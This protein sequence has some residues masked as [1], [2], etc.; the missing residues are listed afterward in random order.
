MIDALLARLAETAGVVPSYWDLNGVLQE[1]TPDTTRILL[2]T[3]GYAADTSADIR[4]SLRIVDRN[5]CERLL[6]EASVM[7]ES[8]VY[9]TVPAALTERKVRWTLACDDGSARDGLVDLSATAPTAVQ[10]VDGTAFARFEVPLPADIPFG[11]H[12]ITVQIGALAAQGAVICAPRTAYSPEWLKR[13]QRMWGTSCQLYTLRSRQDWGIGDFSDLAALAEMTRAAGGSTVAINPL[14]AL[15]PHRP[16]LCSPYW[17]SS[18]LFINPLYLD[19]TAIPELKDCEAAKELLRDPRFPDRIAQVRASTDVDY[20]RVTRLK[21]DLLEPIV[22]HLDRDPP[23]ELNGFIAEGGTALQHF[24]V[25]CALSDHFGGKSWHAWPEAYQNPAN[26]QVVRWTQAHRRDVRFHLLLQWL[27]QRQFAATAQRANGLEIGLMRDLAVGIS[28]DG[29]DAWTDQKLYPRGTRFGAPPDVFTASGQDWGLPPPNPRALA[30]AGYRPFIAAM[31]SNMANA[32]ALRIDH[33][34]SLERLFWIPTGAVAKDGAYVRY[35]FED[36]L[37]IV[38]LESLRA[39]CLVVGEDLG[40]M[41]AD[42]RARMQQEN[43]LST[44]VFLFER[45]DSMLFKRPALYPVSAAAQ[46]TTHDTPTLAGYWQ[47]RDLEIRTGIFHDDLPKQ[48]AERDIDRGRILAALRDQDLIGAGETPEVEKL[49]LAIHRFMARTP[50]QLMLVSAGD[51]M[52]AVEQVNLPG[53]MDEYPNWRKK[54][55]LLLEELAALPAWTETARA[56][57]EGRATGL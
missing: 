30:E 2:K 7:R 12:Q 51:I 20:A 5:T 46:A 6:P 16:E 26:D 8:H 19:L 1:T 52:A 3:M 49:I 53:T 43:V 11:Y 9:V 50:S 42:F 57:S 24:A 27:V 48:Q 38:A 55:P 34:M 13:G 29:A 54:L 36:L 22:N 33:V 39:R 47:G 35:P 10:A 45:Y 56:V 28:P 17:P 25:F 23:A 41:A 4:D 31:R 15:F 18:R 37:G 44:R 40:T 14:H 32:G 21:Y